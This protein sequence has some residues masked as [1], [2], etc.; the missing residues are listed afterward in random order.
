MSIDWFFWL[1][2]AAYC[3]HVVEEATVSG[4]FVL[5]VQRN[6]WPQYSW[7]R[8]GWF[9]T[10]IF[11]L[12]ASSI[13]L[14]EHF[15]TAWLLVPLSFTWFFTVNGLWHLWRTLVTRHFAPG[16]ITGQLYWI[17]MYLG[18]RSIVVPGLI[19]P[20]VFWTAALIGLIAHV[21]M[22]A[23]LHLAPNYIKAGR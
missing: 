5:M 15:G 18:Y 7:E 17:G 8:F 9:N 13:F 1:F 21:L 23:S 2:Y 16:L 19:Q 10:A 12:Y 11:V 3:L 22:I 4:G 6:F 14:F 20:S